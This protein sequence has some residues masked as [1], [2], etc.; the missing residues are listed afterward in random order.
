MSVRANLV[1]LLV[2]TVGASFPL[3]S[4]LADQVIGLTTDNR[5]ISFDSS[6][7]GL[8]NQLG[9]ITGLGAGE[10]I[11]GI[12]QR[13]LT[14]QIIALGSSS[15]VYFIN[16]LTGAA[17]A[18]G[19]SFTPGL[20]AGAEYGIDI[21]PTVDRLRVVNSVGDNRRLNPLNGQSVSPAADTALT[22][23]APGLGTPRAVGTAY[24]N[25][26]A[27][28]PLG[29]VRQFIIDSNLDML[30]EVG[31]QAGGNASFNGGVVTPRG[32]FGPGIDTNDFVGFDISGLTGLALVSLTDP[33][34][35]FSSLYTINLADGSTSPLGAIGAQLTIRD[36]T[37]IPGP[38][39]AALLAFAGVSM[40]RRRRS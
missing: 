4:A 32:S 10:S 36:I 19:A 28:A 5:L 22:Y 39:S 21:N 31:S 25:S 35:N 6:T 2:S 24:T 13:P 30:G 1:A 29:S 15:T 40:A 7:P 33:A 14:G 38:A 11:L 37:I 34:S 3:S 12:D 9:P 8:V 27:N 20:T 23:A 18:A 16:P 26:I 17:S